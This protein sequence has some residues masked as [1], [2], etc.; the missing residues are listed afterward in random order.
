M[1]N[2]RFRLLAF[3]GLVGLLFLAEASLGWAQRQ[4]KTIVVHATK[5]AFSPP[6]SKMPLIPPQR[7]RAIALD[8]ELPM[9]KRQVRTALP[10]SVQQTTLPTNSLTANPGLN[11]LGLGTGLNGFVDQ[12]GTPDTNGAVGTTQ[13]VQWVNYSF[14]AFNKADGSVAFGPAAGN[15][16]WQALGGPCFNHNNLDPIAQFDKLANRWV[17]MMPEFV[18]PFYLCVA[19]S[20][21]SDFVTT[22][23]NLYQF[24]IP[25][26]W[27]P[28]YPKLGVWPDAYYVTYNQF[29]S[30]GFFGPAACALDRNNMLV[31]NPA[32]MQC[33]TN[34]GASFGSLLPGD[35]DGTTPPPTGA[36][37]TFANFDP[38]G[39]SLDL[40]QFH[41]DFT[42][43]ANSTFTGPTNIPVAAFTEGCG[44]GACIPQQGV[45]QILNSYGD[46]IMYR[47]PYR[48]FGDHASLLINHTVNPG[49]GNTGIRWYELQDSG[50]G[51]S[52][53]Q[54]G[55]YAPDSNYRWMGSI[56][57][58]KAGDIALGYSVSG[59]T[60]TPSI[61]YT[62]H[63]STDPPGQMEGEVD[64]L[65][66]IG[67]PHGSQT[68][69]SN[70]GD[71]SSMAI[72]PTDDCTFWYTTEYQPNLG[73][74]W[75]T[76]IASFS[77]PACTGAPPPPWAVVNKASRM[78]PITSLTIPATGI[79][80]LIAVALAFNGSTSV[81][82]VSDNAGNTY[83]SAGARSVLG[84]LSVEIWYAVNSTPGA[85]VVT[86]KFVGSP[87][88][89]AITTWEVSG[90]STGKPDN[91]N[92]AVGVVTANTLGPAVTTS[93]AGDFMVSAIFAPAGNFT[94]ISSGNEFTSDF[95]TSSNG[96]AHITSNS[97]TVGTHQASWSSSNPIGR[98]C[99]S[100]VAFF[101]AP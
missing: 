1:T 48:K 78:G 6:L 73:F 85:T 100:A 95:N 94:G 76:R 42:T 32:T 46:R 35:L 29:S 4:S 33:F 40:W 90:I 36:P 59:T 25:G 43:P 7:S 65:T 44:G 31:G 17:M 12:V 66:S 70:W 61:R 96:W 84:A 24:S 57:M 49:S 21:T 20:N 99:S 27:D 34:I 63:M 30:S 45:Q 62:G 86:A 93:Q 53:F 67:V 60:L 81:A 74:N 50:S 64:V 11:F 18:A 9:F 28:D 5:R 69:R 88:H 77:F 72:D 39:A 10:D 38:N 80:N 71:Y 8:H 82:S 91:M 41:V 98:F 13:F 83:A 87:P 101:T 52:L 51:F 37:D 58:D 55:T 92:T 15:T 14:A 47:L 56:A 16:L 19:V 26:R 79:G 97:A 2:T 22:T 3:W 23:W 54:Q 89:V 68:N 75:S